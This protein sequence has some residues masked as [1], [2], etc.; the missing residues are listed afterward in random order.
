M[1][2]VRWTERMRPSD[3]ECLVADTASTVAERSGP[4]P[5]DAVKFGKS[6]CWLGASGFRHQ[7]DVSISLMERLVLIECKYWNRRIPVGVVLALQSRRT[8]IAATTKQAVEAAVV[9]KV[10]FQAGA[11]QVAEHF[12]IQCQIAESAESWVFKYGAQLVIRSKPAF[13][14]T[15]TSIGS[16][17][18]EPLHGSER[19]S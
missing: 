4:L 8:D 11:K 6:N 9:S 16:Y 5:S 3:Y 19:G 2:A 18:V 12:G 10:G 17:R 7:V 13:A 15:S 1:S 14:A